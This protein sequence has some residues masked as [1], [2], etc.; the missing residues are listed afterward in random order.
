M[1]TNNTVLKGGLDSGTTGTGIFSGVAEER[2]KLDL[3]DA[4]KSSFLDLEEDELPEVPEEEEDPEQNLIDLID[5]Y[6]DKVYHWVLNQLVNKHEYESKIAKS[7]DD[8]GRKKVKS[9]LELREALAKFDQKL[10]RVLE[11]SPDDRR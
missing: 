5:E 9:G 2:Q 8:Y 3:A 7:G 1:S 4:R 10:A 6:A 11:Y